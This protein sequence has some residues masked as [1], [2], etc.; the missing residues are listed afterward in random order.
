[1]DGP[2]EK[3]QVLI[4]GLLLMVLIVS[5]FLVLLNFSKKQKEVLKNYELPAKI[6]YQSR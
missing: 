5:V 6:K 4:E 1:M 2:D 3:G